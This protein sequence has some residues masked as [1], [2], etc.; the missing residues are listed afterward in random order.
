MLKRHILVKFV[1]CYG[2]CQSLRIFSCN[3]KKGK[4]N[5]PIGE[6][7]WNQ[8]LFQVQK[9]VNQV[10]KFDTTK[11]LQKSNREFKYDIFIFFLQFFVV[12]NFTT[13]LFPLNQL[14]MIKTRW[15]NNLKNQI[16]HCGLRLGLHNF[17]GDPWCLRSLLVC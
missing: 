4:Y 8:Q 15:K 12:S 9:G 10:I 14:Q 6:I 13:S 17:W 2:G 11:K 5:Y 1:T 3:I 16:F 7:E